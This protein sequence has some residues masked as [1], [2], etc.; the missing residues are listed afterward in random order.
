MFD[1]IKKP[2]KPEQDDT[3]KRTINGTFTLSAQLPNGRALNVQGYVFSDD[4]KDDLDKR[5]D[6]VQEAIERQ[7]HRCEIPELEARVDQHAQALVNATEVIRELEAKARDGH[8]SSQERLNLQNQRTHSKKI[9][10]EIEKGRV[11][12][13]EAKKKAGVR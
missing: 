10:E 8:L 7:R 4:K 1:N 11:A 12:I 6:F 3:D 5:L 13:V 2:A 9:N